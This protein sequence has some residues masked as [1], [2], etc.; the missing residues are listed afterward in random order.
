[1]MSSITFTA[2]KIEDVASTSTHCTVLPVFKG[3]KL[4]PTA[5]QLDRAAGGAISSALKLGD[6]TGKAGEALMLPGAGKARRVLLIGCGAAKTFDRDAARKFCDQIAASL[7]GCSATDA[8]IDISGLKPRDGD[9]AWLL[10]H[11]SRHLVSSAYRYTRTVSNPKPQLKLRKVTVN[12]DGRMAVAGARKALKHGRCTGIGI[13]QARELANLPG[14]ICTPAYLAQ[15][16]RKLGRD[17]AKL[18]VSVLEE[19]KM[20]ELGMGSLLSVSAGSEQPAKLI[21]MQYK[22]GKSG[23][24]P[25]VL[26]GKGITFDSGG[27]SLKPGAKMDEM[28]FDMGGA[29]SVF[30][31]MHAV[32][33][34]E[35]PLNVVAIV[36]ASENLPSGRATKPGDVVTSMSGKT[37]EVLNTDAEGRLVLCD[38]LT[39]AE[40]Y[41]PEA[42]IDIATLTGACVVALGSH[43]SGLYAN[44]DALAEQLLTAGTETHDR[45]WRM[46]LWDDYNQQIE[47]NFA[48]LANIGGPG[49]GSITAA[50]F[51]AKFTE[52]YPWA[53]LDIAGSAWNSSPKWATGRPVALLTRYLMDRAG[54]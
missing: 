46:P 13:N 2:R 10:E 32:T 15:Q 54:I 37:I 25:Y 28:K 52:K 33:E 23:D 4:S 14:N 49:G 5:R 11:L 19:K 36:A 34:M 3:V 51:L 47:S 26:V 43:A 7:T 48:D 30:G 38:A 20:R 35:L 22:G 8:L 41:K 40:R 39:Y 21:L 42:V 17:K 6:F 31:T 53:H 1:M 16:A 24:K 50:C 29:A 12:L 9:T 27:I 45:A 44:D 18:S